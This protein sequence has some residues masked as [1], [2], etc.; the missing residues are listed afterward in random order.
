MKRTFAFV[1]IAV[2]ACTSIT[3]AQTG[4]VMPLSP[5]R[6]QA[7][8]AEGQLQG[9]RPLSGDGRRAGGELHHGLARE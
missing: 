8:V 5:E 1:I 3:N 2:L 7:L 6:E 4:D 9:M